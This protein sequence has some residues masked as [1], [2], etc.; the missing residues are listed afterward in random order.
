VVD[1]SAARQQRVQFDRGQVGHP[2]QRRQIPDEA[3][4]DR[5]AGSAAAA[6]LA[7]GDP[8]WPVRRTAL[9]VE[10]LVVDAVG[11]ALERERPLLQVGRSSAEIRR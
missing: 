4:V 6:D 11:K 8:W 3:V 9:L 7:R 1:V 5:L 10:E 2:D